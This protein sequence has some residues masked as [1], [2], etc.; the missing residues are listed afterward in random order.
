MAMIGRLNFEIESELESGLIA[1][2]AGLP[3]LIEAYCCRARPR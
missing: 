1:L 2:R 3:I